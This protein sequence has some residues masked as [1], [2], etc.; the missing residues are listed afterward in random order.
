MTG[1]AGIGKT[2]VLNQYI[3]CLKEREVYPSILAPTGTA[4]SHLGGQTIHSFFSLG[5]KEQVDQEF[6]DSLL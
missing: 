6:L 1:S 4:A 5:I 3:R 2:H